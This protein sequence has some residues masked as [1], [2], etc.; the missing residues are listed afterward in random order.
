ME[1]LSSDLAGCGSM[2]FLGTAIGGLVIGF[3]LVVDYGN[4]MASD[5]WK[6][7][8]ER[9]RST[10]RTMLGE[11]ATLPPSASEDAFRDLTAR[12]KI[13][14]LDVESRSGRTKVLIKVL[15][16][17]TTCAETSIP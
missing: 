12:R 9:A 15:S 8:E 1:S 16:T 6:R 7:A 17:P 13:R 10:G 3:Y 5:N 11:F 2:L 14:V 4:E